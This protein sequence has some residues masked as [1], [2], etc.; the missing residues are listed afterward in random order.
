M[1]GGA[2]AAHLL[3]VD[4][5][6]RADV[7]EL[8]GV[9]SLRL[10]D[11]LRA[12]EAVA[13]G[14]R[15]KKSLYHASINTGPG[16]ELTLEQKAAAV[17]RLELA[18]GLE[19]H[20]RAVVE[21]RKEGRD[22]LHVVWSRIDV[23]TMRATHDG[24]NYR[25][26]EAVARELEREFGHNRVQGAHVERD[27]PEGERRPRPARTPS[28]GDV[29]QATRT[30]RGI[31]EVTA[32]L[33]RLW[34]AAD[35]GPAFAAA[36]EGAGY[37]LAQG[38]RRGFVVIDQAGAVHSLARRIEGAKTKDVNARLADIDPAKLR[39]V[40]EARAMQKDPEAERR[41]EEE[42]QRDRRRA[43]IR[44]DVDH[45]F[46][47]QGIGPHP[48]K[49]PR[50]DPA[51]TVVQPTFDSTRDQRRDGPEGKDRGPATQ[52][53]PRAESR[54]SPTDRLRSELM[55]PEVDREAR[56]ERL[57]AAE[58]D[59]AARATIRVDLDR[60]REEMQAKGYQPSSG[61]QEGR[62]AEGSVSPA[63]TL[64]AP[65]PEAPQRPSHVAEN[66]NRLPEPSPPPENRRERA[67]GNRAAVAR[68]PVKPQTAKESGRAI[69]Q[70]G[71]LLG[72]GVGKAA[73]GLLGLFGKL[74]GAAAGTVDQAAKP[75]PTRSAAPAAPAARPEPRPA[76]VSNPRPAPPPRQPAPRAPSVF[77]EIDREIKAKEQARG[78]QPAP[79]RDK[80]RDRGRG[81]EFRP[82]TRLA[83]I[84]GQDTSW[85]AEAKR[86]LIAYSERTGMAIFEELRELDGII[87]RALYGPA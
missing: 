84:I 35:T 22:H 44:R 14:T 48:G 20:A 38:D 80:E 53:D 61:S 23:D 54:P 5:N 31:G 68:S 11:A 55:R 39:T 27:G 86:R 74:L 72:R 62:Q 2:L 41:Q 16:E 87:H 40:D 12:M 15:C 19:G 56:S 52:A 59:Q 21:H 71:G 7:L 3:R 13:L 46:Y 78:P 32:D 6:E 64:Q 58:R 47:H 4:T 69:G 50:L 45:D 8:K 63:T 57:A 75:P 66:R 33:T 43:E 49:Q 42:A 29:Q 70:A 25:K 10:P 85:V 9:D 26:H 17:A 60:H 34:R 77:D 73:G 81:M 51:K 24:H 18:L 67:D 30:K 65:S 76:P 36:L 79:P 83:A 82:I 1:G 37:V 28:P